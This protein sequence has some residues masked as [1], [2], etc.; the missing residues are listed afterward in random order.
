[1][2]CLTST[3]LLS[4]CLT[5]CVSMR[6]ETSTADR[7]L[8]RT[9]IPQLCLCG[10]A[11]RDFVDFANGAAREF[12]DPNDPIRERIRIVL[13]ATV[14]GTQSVIQPIPDAII[15]DHCDTPTGTIR[16]TLDWVCAARHLRYRVHGATVLIQNEE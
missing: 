4:L 6:S 11:L 15:I 13:D 9:Y 8:S 7:F 3:V 1:M 10:A 14:D 12:G 5:S 2:Q 16:A